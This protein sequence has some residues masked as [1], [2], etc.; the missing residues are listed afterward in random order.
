MATLTAPKAMSS[1]VTGMRDMH[2]EA[3]GKSILIQ[4]VSKSFGGLAA[5]RDCTVEIPQGCVV[6][7]VG[8]NGAGKSTL[9]NLITG[10]IRPDGGRIIYKGENLVGLS[11][12]DIFRR[13]IV[14]S[15]QGIKTFT[16]LSV[17]ENLLVSATASYAMSLVFRPKEDRRTTGQTLHRAWEV[18]SYLGL[19]GTGNR[20]AGEL[21]Y[22]EQKLLSIGRMMM[23]DAHFL[24][25]DEPLGGLNK[26]TIGNFIERIRRLCET[27]RHSVCIVEH[28]LNAV[29]QISD[30][31]VFMAEGTVKAAG[32]TEEILTSKDL[33]RLYLGVGQNG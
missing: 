29:R 17:V 10:F 25:L 27:G 33:A 12:A 15:F 26:A 31:V 23:T 32:P 21:G 2:P 19:E 30:H 20:I 4:D 22:G 14:R 24:L 3:K 13:G 18:L 1:L 6:G 16:R 9:F 11:P 5:V 28:N 8:P 7:I